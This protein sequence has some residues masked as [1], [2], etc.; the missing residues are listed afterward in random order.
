[1]KMKYTK[2][3]KPL[4]E[5]C[6]KSFKWRVI[7]RTSSSSYHVQ[8]QVIVQNFKLDTFTLAEEKWEEI[9]CLFNKQC[10]LLGST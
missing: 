3:I 7:V 2:C 9:N 1:M 8:F 6:G 5:K 4:I 10:W